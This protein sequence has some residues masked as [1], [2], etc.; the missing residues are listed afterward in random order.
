MQTKRKRLAVNI[1]TTNTWTQL[2]DEAGTYTVPNL[3]RH[4][5]TIIGWG[6]ANLGPNA[7]TVEIAFSADSSIADVERMY[8]P[9]SLATATNYESYAPRRLRAGEG[10]WARAVGVAPNVT[11]W[12]TVDEVQEN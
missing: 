7:A 10:L 11:F 2:S 1:T 9:V 5:G 4:T 6:A 8:A 3:A 12:A